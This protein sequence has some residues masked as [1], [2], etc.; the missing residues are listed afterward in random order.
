MPSL[1]DRFRTHQP[2]QGITAAATLLTADPN[3]K[4]RNRVHRG[5]EP[6]QIEAW[7]AY[8]DLGEISYP[9]NYQANA[10][11][12]IRPVAA[13]QVDPREPPVVLDG[14]GD[15]ELDLTDDERA[16]M[17]ATV[18]R[19]GMGAM[20]PMNEIQRLT[21]LNFS[22]AGDCYLVGW[23][24]PDKGECWDVLSVEEFI[25]DPNGRGWGRRVAG[26]GGT[27]LTQSFPPDA[28]VTRLFQRDARFSG[29]SYSAMRSVLPLTDE[30]RI[31]TD[32]VRAIAMSRI[33][34]GIIAL[35]HGF[36]AGGPKDERLAG[37]RDEA[38][39]DPVVMKYLEHFEA[40]IKNRKSASAV[41]PFLLFGEREDINSGIKVLEFNRDI[42]K[43]YMDLRAEVIRRIGVGVDLPPEVLTGLG[44]VKYWNAQMIDQSTFKYHLEPDAQQMFWAYTY[45]YYRP[46]LAKMGLENVGRCVMW[47]DPAPLVSHPNQAQDYSEGHDR[48]IVSDA[49]WRRVH[50]VPDED[51]P[52][53]QERAQ[54]IWVKTLEHGRTAPIVFPTP[55]QIE[56]GA[57]ESEKPS[58]AGTTG[59]DVPAISAGTPAIPTTPPSAGPADATTPKAA[60]AIEVPALAALTASAAYSPLGPRLAN[61]EKA[62]RLRLMQAADDATTRALEKA[63]NKLRGLASKGSTEWRQ[64]L[65]GVDALDVAGR[66]GNER[67]ASLAASPD[68]LLA[69]AF[70]GVGASFTTWVKRAQEQ[71]LAAVDQHGTLSEED[72]VQV[73]Q[74]MDT[75][76][77]EGLAVF[78]AGLAIAAGALLYA[79]H[80]E[81]PARGEWSD[82]RVDPTVVTDALREAGGGVSDTLGTSGLLSGDV[83]HQALVDAGLSVTGYVWIHGDPMRDFEPHLLLDGQEFASFTDDVL[84]NAED[85]PDVA[86]FSPNNGPDGPDHFSCSC[87]AELQIERG[88]MT[89]N[90]SSDTLDETGG[91]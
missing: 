16:A 23:N 17:N 15:D 72:A 22:L 21:S 83:F 88:D 81:A 34:A 71:A 42:D 74:T 8:Y 77:D 40:P 12:R 4:E 68:D 66:L 69:D 47:Y 64:K 49:A 73:T 62:L 14:D 5:P 38:P 82:F 58:G 80:V 28:F 27:A 60:T 87:V 7:N 3:D 2:G 65:A 76:R 79:P 6:W 51:A 39:N 63:G 61:I 46:H 31:L 37:Q 91:A 50:G 32:A 20:I 44:D 33:P 43:L 52:D 67:V 30:L 53:E 1:F 19:L 24:D 54:R 9:M 41:T 29:R 78:L 45:G 85:W 75:A 90:E 57:V 13:I 86:Y 35:S 25:A 89:G 59:G 36:R 70:V 11:A 26:Y 56:A 10:L 18:D 55:E 84:T 48:V